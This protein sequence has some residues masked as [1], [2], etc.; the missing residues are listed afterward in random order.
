MLGM[1]CMKHNAC[2]AWPLPAHILEDRR[3][4]SGAEVRRQ[5]ADAEVIAGSG[6]QLALVA[7]GN[8]YT[9][10][11]RATGYPATTAGFTLI[12]LRKIVF[13]SQSFHL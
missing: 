7:W 13:P 9:Y 6:A 10:T 5:M 12:L 3:Q 4:R 1:R 11:S 8:D 2:T